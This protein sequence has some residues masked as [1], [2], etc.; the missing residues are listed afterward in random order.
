[1]I[2]VF[3]FASEVVFSSINRMHIVLVVLVIACI[4]VQSISNNLLIDVVI[5]LTMKSWMKS[6]IIVVVAVY[7]GIDLILNS[8]MLFIMGMRR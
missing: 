8:L 4:S 1:M 3:A 5:A 6:I 7:S 2:I